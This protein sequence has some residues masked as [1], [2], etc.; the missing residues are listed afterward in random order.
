MNSIARLCATALRPAFG[1]ALLASPALAAIDL[2]GYDTDLMRDLEKT[3]KYFE[4]DIAAKNEQGAK[5][6]AEVLLDG[7][8]YTESYFSKKGA[9]DA[10][11]ISR[12]GVKLVDA[13]LKNVAQGD[14]EAAAAAAR[15]ATQA[16]KSCHDLYKPRLAR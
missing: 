15:E 13:A 9:Q 16:C 2:Q 8:R 10:V 6:D 4:P 14:F 5:E 1:A 11:D 7:F 3:V 12:N